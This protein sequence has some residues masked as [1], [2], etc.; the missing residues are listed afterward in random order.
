MRVIAGGRKG[1]SMDHSTA[2]GHTERVPFMELLK[3]ST[4][5]V[6]TLPL[7]PDTRNLLSAAEF[8]IMRPDAILINLSRGGVV[9]E[10]DLLAS[11]RKGRKHERGGI[12]GAAVDV[13]MTEPATPMN[14]V[15]AEAASKVGIKQEALNLTLTPHIAWYGHRTVENLQAMTRA[16]LYSWLKG[17]PENV[18]V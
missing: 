15:L 16:G 13:F 2:D 10:S 5:V 14:S 12:T 9:D 18:V 4:I 17:A 7:L 3:R 6:V 8:E 1:A 11:L